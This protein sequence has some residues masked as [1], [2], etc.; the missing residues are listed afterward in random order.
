MTDRRINDD[1][2]STLASAVTAADTTL[3]VTDAQWTANA[4]DYPL[5][6]RVGGEII[7]A[8][9]VTGSTTQTFLGCERAVNGI[10]KAHPAGTQVRVAEPWRLTM[11]HAAP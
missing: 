8:T 10:V 11:S 7:S 6:L 9:S 4:A 5:L 2:T 1:G 3:P